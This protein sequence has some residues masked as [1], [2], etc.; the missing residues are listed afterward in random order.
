MV[1]V[2]KRVLFAW[3]NIPLSLVR[4]VPAVQTLESTPLEYQGLRVVSVAISPQL[5]TVEVTR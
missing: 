5:V 3:V 2:S 4:Q 1:K